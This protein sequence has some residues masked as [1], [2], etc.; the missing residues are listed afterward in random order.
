[1]TTTEGT[2]NKRGPYARSQQ[3]RETIARAVLDIV[4]E[5]GHE[6]V[7]TALVAERSGTN[8]ATLL[9]HFPTKDH[10]VIAAL[11]FSDSLAAHR[12][13][14]T[15][16]SA[17]A[18]DLDLDGLREVAN[19][20]TQTELHRRRLYQVIKGQAV[21]EDHPA[22]EYI[23]HRTAAAIELWTAVVEQQQRSG[24]AHPSLDPA[25]VGRQVF[26]LWEG[27]ATMNAVDP[28][29]DIGEMLL[30]GIRRL[31]GRNWTEMI[32]TMTTPTAGL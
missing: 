12:D 32:A 11:E 27:L 20:R 19:A 9:Y 26:A 25:A 2:R 18:T 22:A 10:L 14:T 21:S 15:G 1:M 29:L 5:L 17:L 23:A 13:P 7:T 28:D 6:K 31:T 16:A 8:E 24:L 4:D 3:R 30:D